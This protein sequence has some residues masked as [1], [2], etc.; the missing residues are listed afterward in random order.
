M[1]YDSTKGI[2]KLGAVMQERMQKVNGMSPQALDFGVIQTDYSLKTNSYTKAI[3][4]TDYSVLIDLTIGPAGGVLT[5][6]LSDGRHGGHE[7]GNGSHSHTIAIPEKLR[8]L[9]PGDRVLVAWVQ[10]EA[11][12]VGRV[13][14]L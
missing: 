12:V 13:V 6:T 14:R 1:A 7:S 4:K 8:A 9:A 3:P 11:V 2:S 10:S 5:N